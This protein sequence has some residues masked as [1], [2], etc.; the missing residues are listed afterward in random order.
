MLSL[1]L[2]PIVVIVFS[3]WLDLFPQRMQR[4]KLRS[5]SS[6]GLPLGCVLGP[7]VA[8]AV[9]G[10][11]LGHS[12]PTK[13]LLIYYMICSSCI[14]LCPLLASLAYW[15]AYPTS[16][17]V[18]CSILSALLFV[19]ELFL[20]TPVLFWALVTCLLC[21]GIVGWM[22]VF[23]PETFTLGEA[24]T[25]SQGVTFLIFDITSQ[26]LHKAGVVI[27]SDDV[28]FKRSETTLYLEMTMVGIILCCGC[29]GPVLTKAAI[30]KDIV[31]RRFWSGTFFLASGMIMVMILLPSLQVL[32]EN[33]PVLWLFAFIMS[34][35]YRVMLIGYWLLWTISAIV[36]A[37]VQ[38]W[39]TGAVFSVLKSK[40]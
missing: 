2:V 13:D 27:L 1:L 22:L 30:A 5:C 20:E 23:F 24:L 8:A 35:K 16:I 18:Y 34:S 29:L 10:S 12:A 37:V 11:A 9:C 38:S 7:M 36:F 6:A 31:E 26:I 39:T 3:A 15:V 17:V 32:L 4:I 14:G 19:M 40:E 33:G 21:S 28:K 25:I